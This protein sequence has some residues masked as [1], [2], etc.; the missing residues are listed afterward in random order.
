MDS[1][2]ARW[3]TR[4][5]KKRLIIVGDVHGCYQEL[6][7]L[8]ERCGFEAS[9]DTVAFVGDL[10]SKGPYSAEVV[11]L[12]RK[13]NALCVLGN[14]DQRWLNFFED[15]EKNGTWPTTSLRF[16][17]ALERFTIDDWLWMREVPHG[18]HIPQWDCRIVH[19]GLDPSFTPEM[20]SVITM[21]NVRNILEDGTPSKELGEG[22]A[23]ASLWNGPTHVYFG[24]DARRKLQ[25]HPFATGLDTG[26]VYGGALTACILPEEQFVT[27]VPTQI[28]CQ[29]DS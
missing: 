1:G 9:D 15:K 11:Q 16:R 17:D 28:Y 3:I 5:I 26:C 4:K 8:L 6:V 14:H 27:A 2:T 23:W 18:L 20:Q 10:V 19:A 21:L 29:P 24:H 12:A 13:L 22:V 7:Q 25:R